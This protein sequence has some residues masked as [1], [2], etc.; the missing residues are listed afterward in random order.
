MLTGHAT[1]DHG[2]AFED[3]MG[4]LHQ[5]FSVSK[6]KGLS[7]PSIFL[8]LV[9]SF[10]C[11]ILLSSL[12]HC[13]RREIPL[14]W[15][16]VLLLH[17]TPNTWDSASCKRGFDMLFRYNA[18]PQLAPLLYR[19]WQTWAPLRQGIHVVEVVEWIHSLVWFRIGQREFFHMHFIWYRNEPP[20]ISS[21]IST[22]YVFYRY[23]SVNCTI[24]VIQALLLGNTV[25]VH[26]QLIWE[27]CLFV[28]P[29]AEYFRL[30]HR[31]RMHLTLEA[32]VCWLILPSPHVETP[33]NFYCFPA[34]RIRLIIVSYCS[35]RGLLAV[36]GVM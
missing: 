10:H 8:M 29:R 13:F 32:H 6:L 17:V 18:L 20:M 11:Y 15:N 4:G 7:F 3:G 24:H 14:G 30:F 33:R 5:H 12:Q 36:H 31:F 2:L 16:S 34:H 1:A 23:F 35:P 27:H 21:G 9:S 19:L 26:S 25:K 28:G 22:L